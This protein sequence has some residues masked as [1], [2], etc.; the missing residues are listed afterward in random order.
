MFTSIMP[1]MSNA[2][3]PYRP[4]RFFG[5]DLNESG[6]M[7]VELSIHRD[8]WHRDIVLAV[9]LS[10]PLSAVWEDSN[11]HSFGILSLSYIGG[12]VGYALCLP[13]RVL[14]VAFRVVGLFFQTILCMAGLLEKKSLQFSA[15]KTLRRFLEIFSGTVGVVCPPA[16]YFL[17]RQIDRLADKDETKLYLYVFKAPISNALQVLG[18]DE[19]YRPK[20]N[21]INQKYKQESL[22][23]HPDKASNGEEK[24]KQITQ[25]KKILDDYYKAPKD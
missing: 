10:S 13:Y 5:F 8:Q 14:A 9:P 25:A 18:F 2:I 20:M 7:N 22:K 19:G 24:I 11:S 3:T 16:G 1:D 23:Y 17:D 6:E 21:E 12:T 4:Q 15:L